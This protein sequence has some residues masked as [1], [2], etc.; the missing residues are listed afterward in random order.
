M[1]PYVV[2]EMLKTD[3]SANIAINGAMDNLSINREN[4]NT[5]LIIKIAGNQRLNL[6]VKLVYE[7]PSF[8]GKSLLDWKKIDDAMT[9]R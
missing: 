4:L 6:R 7:T 3:L 1:K 8:D 2:Y 5:S 9:A